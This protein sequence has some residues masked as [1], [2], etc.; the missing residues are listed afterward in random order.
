MI[1][2][3]FTAERYHLAPSIARGFATTYRNDAKEYFVFCGGSQLNKDLYEKEFSDFSFDKYTFCQSYWQ[4]LKLL[5]RFRSNA[6]LFHAGNY[7]WHLT[8]LLLGCKNVNWV[9][10]GGGTSI[11]NNWRSKWI[12]KVKRFVFNR[13][14][15]IVTLM[16]PERQDLINN[17]G[18][19][20]EKIK[21]ISYTST[22]LKETELDLLCK[23]LASKESE[24]HQKP[25]VLLGNSHNWLNSY[26]KFIPMLA[27]YMLNYPFEKGKTY[28]K[29]IS[30]GK[31]MFGDDFK[32]NENFYSDK[33]DYI[34]Y[35]NGCDIYICAVKQQTGLGAIRFC[36]ELGKKIYITG[37]NLEWIRQ[38]YKSIVY[39]I[40][41]ISDRL[42][43]EEFA[44][45]L[46]SDVKRHNYQSQ[47][48]SIERN[49]EKWHTYLKE[50]ETP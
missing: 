6:L 48:D 15:S 46:S 30:L 28:E 33:K 29:L 12:A 50:M 39:P 47:V 23:Q 8:A 26:I 17:F 3:F 34:N 43:F 10:W 19:N 2:H 11:S 1:V 41:D 42:S 25:I 45:P 36:L 16:E 4:L 35:L 9:C 14:H 38:E 49:R 20:P 7:S 27:Q 18:V 37:D 31:S 13:Y 22:A 21:T 40:E 24:N 44:R 5:V 32:T